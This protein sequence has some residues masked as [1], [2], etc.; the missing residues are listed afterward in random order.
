MA[1]TPLW[2]DAVS[3]CADQSRETE[4]KS[5]LPDLPSAFCLKYK[6]DRIEI[7]RIYLYSI[8]N[9]DENNRFHILHASHIT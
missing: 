1:P 7:D 5:V 6:I 3:L 9:K 2:P 4:W 8:I